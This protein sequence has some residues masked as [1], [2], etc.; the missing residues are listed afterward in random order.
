M[1]A[2]QQIANA[3]GGAAVDLTPEK[4]IDV[5]CTSALMDIGGSSLV[6]EY[7]ARYG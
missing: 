4:L 6:A 7:K 1:A 2:F 3:T 5:V